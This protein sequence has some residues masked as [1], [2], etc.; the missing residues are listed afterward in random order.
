MSGVIDFLYKLE[1]AA[2]EAMDIDY[3]GSS[4][5]RLADLMSSHSIAH[6]IM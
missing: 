3:D 6:G 4:A 5:D 2:E 1:R